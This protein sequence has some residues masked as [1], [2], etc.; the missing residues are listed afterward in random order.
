[1]KKIEAIVRPFKV[2]EVK[3]A[4]LNAGVSGITVTEVKAFGR[5]KGRTELYRGAGYMVDFVPKVKMEVVASDSILEGA[6]EAF[7][8]AAYTGRMGD[9]EIYISTIERAMH[10]RTGEDRIGR[11]LPAHRTSPARCSSGTLTGTTKS[12]LTV[13]ETGLSS[14]GT[15]WKR[16]ASITCFLTAVHQAPSRDY[17]PFTVPI[18]LSS[19]IHRTPSG[20]GVLSKKSVP[21][22]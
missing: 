7:L 9:G 13:A 4:L 15:T 8:K 21:S 3:E 17:G 18:D 1:M 20:A 5:Q 12:D 16:A 6:V 19:S 22:R 2:D 14:L 10:I 11:C